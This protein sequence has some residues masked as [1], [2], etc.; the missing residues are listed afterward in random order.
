MLPVVVARQWVRGRAVQ[1]RGLELTSEGTFA[2]RGI[3]AYDPTR[4][5][6][7]Q[8]SMRGAW[9]GAPEARLC[10]SALGSD[11]YREKWSMVALKKSTED[12]RGSNWYRRF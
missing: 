4:T 7:T 3:G 6:A 5:L 9:L 12:D 1:L 11:S 8:P 2:T 10:L